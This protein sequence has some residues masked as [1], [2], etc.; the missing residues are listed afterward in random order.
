MLKLFTR[1]GACG[2]Q[3]FGSNA[4]QGRLFLALASGVLLA[5]LLTAIVA[6]AAER[7]PLPAI[8][9]T[10]VAGDTLSLPELCRDKPTLIYFWATWCK[11]CS[12]HMPKAIRLQ[13]DLGDG[14]R[15]FG[16]AWK[17]TREKV[18]AYFS[19]REARLPTYL[20]TDGR[21]FHAFNVRQTPHVVIADARGRVVFSGY[22]S[23]RKF[24]RI[25]RKLT[26]EVA[27][28]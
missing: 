3:G 23:F 7:A 18:E 19:R 14:I 22:G 11:V 9:V 5:V 28:E 4:V 24:R 10:S 13:R 21:L 20:D 12:K 2:R 17:E 6:K 1:R 26:K 15:V 16:V 8:Q 27:P 25:L